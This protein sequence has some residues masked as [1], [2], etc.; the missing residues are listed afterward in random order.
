MSAGPFGLRL[1]SDRQSELRRMAALR[2]SPPPAPRSDGGPPRP[3][4]RRSAL[5]RPVGHLL[6]RA[7]RWV[8]GPEERLVESRSAGLA[9]LS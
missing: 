2:P 5:R 1:A 8:A 6:I 4:G 3:T 9:S 7:G